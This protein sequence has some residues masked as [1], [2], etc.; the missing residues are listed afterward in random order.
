MTADTDPPDVPAAPDAPTTPNRRPVPNTLEESTLRLEGQPTGTP[1]EIGPLPC[2]FGR[3][4]LVK[5][6]GRGGMGTVYLAHD[7]IL[8]R[9]VGLKVPHTDVLRSPQ[10][11]ERFYR[12]A[13]AAA[14]L[15]H[16]NICQIH[17]VGSFEGQHFITMAYVEGVPLSARV[18]PLVDQPRVVAELVRTLALA[19]DEAHRQGVIHRDLKPANIMLDARGQ[20]VIMDFGLARRVE[21]GQATH[22][23]QGIILG[24]PAYMPPEQAL[25]DAATV[26]PRSDV[27]SLG[28]VLYELLAGRVPFDGTVSAVLVQVIHEQP[29]PPSAL[30]SGVDPRLEAICLKAMAKRPE[31]RFADMEEYAAALDDY[32]AGRTIQ[33]DLAAP[34]SPAGHL[35]DSILREFRRWGYARGME[36]VRPWLAEA[37]EVPQK[38]VACVLRWLEG[39][40]DVQ[41]AVLEQFRDEPLLPVVTAWVLAGRAWTSL[42]QFQMT[43]AQRE[44]EE[45]AAVPRALDRILD[46]V[47]AYL[48][49][50]I[51]SREGKWEEAIPVLHQALEQLGRDHFLTGSVL[52]TLGRVYAGKCNL[53]AACEFY[54]QA[55]ACK[56]RAGD[57][58][59]LVLTF[60]EIG[61]LYIESEDFDRA[62][63]ELEEGLQ[64]AERLSDEAAQARLQNHLGRVALY[65]GEREAAM[66]KQAAAKKLYRQAAE[67]LDWAVATYQRLG[68]AV[69]E[70]RAR[71]Y[72]AMTRLHDGRIE[73]AEQHLERG[74]NLLRDSGHPQ[75]LAEVH[76][77]LARVRVAQ[78]RLDEAMQL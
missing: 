36:S 70:G 59:G 63:A 8:E 62:E 24:T 68:L 72:V 23:S 34:T 12:E 28:V 33:A 29:A 21:H 10:A 27:Y 4:R 46:G 64:V 22:T 44:I 35:F 3:Y 51:H 30:R 73:E 39:D 77:F 7:P 49:G 48:R 31:D 14:R 52:D 32:L 2:S 53:Q 25:G 11:L 61:R 16:R 38:D 41:E 75:G 40:R 37:R 76:R 45:A 58:G 43:R 57:E 1:G 5:Q 69:P 66:G 78:G 19:L 17:D 6:L 50:Y 42:R 54:H 26:G 15:N 9:D 56:Q 65:R 47:L 18:A 13:R 55:L 20:P 67:Y 60:E 71:K 74:L